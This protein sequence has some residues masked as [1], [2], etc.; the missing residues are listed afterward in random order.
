MLVAL[1]C[2][3]LGFYITHRVTHALHAPLMSITNAI[4][5]IVVIGSMKCILCA[6]SHFELILSFLSLLFGSVNI[7][8]GFKI[9]HRMIQMFRIKQ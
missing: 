8:G 7:G 1:L 2:V 5:S 9:S 3:F 6:T 4:S